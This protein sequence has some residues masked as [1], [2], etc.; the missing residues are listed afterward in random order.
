MKL[1]YLKRDLGVALTSFVLVTATCI[2]A[3]RKKEDTNKVDAVSI[4]DYSVNPALVKSLSGFEDL[5]ITTLISSDDVLAES[6]NFVFGAQPDGAGMIPNPNGKGFI[7]INNHEILQSVSRVYL[8]N[9]LK[10]FKG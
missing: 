8:D 1:N 9:N 7:M 4:K 10:P 6:P 2:V 5:K 3:C